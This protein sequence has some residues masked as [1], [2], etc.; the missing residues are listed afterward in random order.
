MNLFKTLQE[1]ETPNKGRFENESMIKKSKGGSPV[2]KTLKI[3][4]SRWP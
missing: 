2:K 3:I 1:A 4:G